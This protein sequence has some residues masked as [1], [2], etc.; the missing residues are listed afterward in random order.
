MV[1]STGLCRSIDH[2]V[3]DLWDLPARRRWPQSSLW[4]S[5]QGYPSNGTA[6]LMSLR[7]DTV[8]VPEADL[9][10]QVSAHGKAKRLTA[11]DLRRARRL[12]SMG[13]MVQ[14]RLGER[15]FGLSDKGTRF[16]E[17]VTAHA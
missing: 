14:G 16:V 7:S 13:L 8:S 15:Y 4:G 2:L 6:H 10:R 11:H 5:C 3:R 17:A 9:M 1:F 12:L